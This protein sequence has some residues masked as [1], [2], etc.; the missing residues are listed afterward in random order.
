MST[1]SQAGG[2]SIQELKEWK[3]KFAK[4]ER[5]LRDLKLEM[6]DATSKKQ[7][8]ASDMQAL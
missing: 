8:N 2:A 1:N 6:Q 5:E 7:S 3:L 4:K